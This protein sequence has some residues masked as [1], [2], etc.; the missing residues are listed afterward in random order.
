[1]KYL[2][3]WH[4]YLSEYTYLCIREPLGTQSQKLFPGTFLPENLESFSQ[5]FFFLAN[6]DSALKVGNWGLVNART[7]LSPD[8]GRPVLDGLTGHGE[9][10]SHLALT[11]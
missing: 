9:L 6:L 3:P 7:T 8:R 1:M 2:W 4:L 10:P 11:L 5:K